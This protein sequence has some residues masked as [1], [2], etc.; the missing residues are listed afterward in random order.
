MPFGLFADYYFYNINKC[1]NL[2][3]R[4]MT[5]KYCLAPINDNSKFC[6]QCG[7]ECDLTSSTNLHKQYEI[8]N[9]EGHNPDKFMNSHDVDFNSSASN[10]TTI[11]AVALS[12]TKYDSTAIAFGV[13]L[14]ICSLAFYRFGGQVN[15]GFSLLILF[16]RIGVAYWCSSKAKELN[17]NIGVWST[18]GFFLPSI[19]LIIIGL[20]N[21][22][23]Y[24]DN[25]YSL[26]SKEKSA[27]NN[28]LA[29]K[30]ASQDDFD[31]ALKFSNLSVAQDPEN[32]VAI[33]T[34]GYI[35]YYLGEYYDAIVDFNK[36]LA[37]DNSESAKYY[38]RGS[39]YREINLLDEAKKDLEIAANMGN[40][41]AR[42]LLSSFV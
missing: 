41:D 32:H 37:I 11:D 42:I 22:V 9:E 3:S 6:S 23:I 31:L 40:E 24:P 1:Q 4:I 33:F 26:P 30:K 25:Y 38:Y 7:R 16:A 29:F 28:N 14:L 34:R 39:T 13:I 17:R 27:I 19:A 20:L 2:I 18:F 5:C 8:L 35:K 12:K 15:L 21:E 36:S 10:N